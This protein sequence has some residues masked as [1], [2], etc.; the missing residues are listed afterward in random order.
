MDQS[1]T[2]PAASAHRRALLRRFATLLS[3]AAVF[4][5]G[6]AAMRRPVDPAANFAA[7]PTYGGL[8][9]QR[10]QGGEE[11]VLV[12]AE[13]TSAESGP[14]HLL[15]SDGRT[16]GALWLS[17]GARVDVRQTAD[18]R[19]PMLGDAQVSWEEG[20]LHLVLHGADGASL[21]TSRFER[22]DSVNPPQDLRRVMA[23]PFAIA[24]LPG[25]YRA[26]LRDAREA[27]VGW[28]QVR[29]LPYVGLPR[30]YDADV[31]A[32]VNE[33]LLAGAVALVDGEIAAIADANAYPEDR[34]PEGGLVP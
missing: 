26:E 19:A 3:A 9:V 11:A 16:L 12:H 34:I 15:E 20:A 30:D 25:V 5:A 18:P 22:L 10:T 33:S 21:H 13:S 23:S 32:S 6:C 7:E 1:T 31:P 17:D 27:A 4:L 28:M 8:V 2:K 24:G 14:T 29:I